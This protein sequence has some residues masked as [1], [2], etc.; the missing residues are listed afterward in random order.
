MRS[1]AI[2]TTALISSA[3]ALVTPRT[4]NDTGIIN[5]FD[6]PGASK[7]LGFA[8]P[9]GAPDGLFSVT[10]DADGVAHHSRIELPEGAPD[11]L[12][13]RDKATQSSLEKRQGGWEYHCGD[14]QTLKKQDTDN[15]ITFLRAFCGANGTPPQW[16]DV[17]ENVWQKSGAV[18]AYFCNF[19]SKRNLCKYWEVDEHLRGQ[20]GRKCGSYKPGWTSWGDYRISMGQERVGS[21]NRFCGRYN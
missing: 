8:I 4:E 15:V 21:D 17:G 14:G 18:V 2:I 7:E 16:V 9:E 10:I 11:S 3:L 12:A 20:V 6:V 1:T 13:A 5:S 19:D